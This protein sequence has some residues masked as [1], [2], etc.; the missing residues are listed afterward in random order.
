MDIYKQKARNLH[1]TASVNINKLQLVV[2]GDVSPT[3]SITQEK[4]TQ[5]VLYTNKVT[6]FTASET[7]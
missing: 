6:V 1:V 5:A 4:Y 3:N 2:Y 7:H